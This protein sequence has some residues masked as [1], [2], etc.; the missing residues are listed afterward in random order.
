MDICSYVHYY[1]RHVLII[2]IYHRYNYT[3]FFHNAITLN[4]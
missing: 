3:T 2:S 1:Y 4:K